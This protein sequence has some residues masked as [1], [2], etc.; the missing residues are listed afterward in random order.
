MSRQRHD[1]FAKQYLAELLEPLG[2]IETSLEVPGEPHFVN[3]HFTPLAISENDRNTLGLLAKMVSS[4][5]LLEP[6]RNQ[7]TKRE[8]RDCLLKLFSV[9]DELQ[10]Q[11]K[12]SSKKYLPE[13]QLPFL[14]IL[15]PIASTTLVTGF[16]ASQILEDWGP[17]IYFLAPD[18]KTAIVAI[19]QLPKTKE[20]LWLRILGKGQIQQKAIEELL[21]LPDDNTL[22][23]MILE[24]LSTWHITMKLKNHLTDDEQELIMNLT[25]AYKQWYQKTLLEGMRQGLHEGLQEG[26]QKGTQQGTQQGRFEERR[27]FIENMLQNR[28]GLLDTTLLQVVEPLVKLSPNELSP[29]LLRYSREE[30]IAKFRE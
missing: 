20:T 30:L 7:P 18:L 29:I 9:H 1:Q 4:I 5:C 6:F 14:W 13:E 19:N 8:M 22:R 2:K 28:F 12:R 15:V 26:L 3:L 24:L 10:R 21:A 17:G 25:P 11:S 16:G 23:L 27:E